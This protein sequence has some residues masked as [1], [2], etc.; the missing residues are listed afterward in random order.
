MSSN[1]IQKY[2]DGL[3]TE[4]EEM[5]LFNELSNNDEM[6]L[7]LRASLKLRETIQSNS[8]N[9]VPQKLLLNHFF[10]H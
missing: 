4:P 5:A 10:L 7:E 6:R 3:L 9:R 2:I 1:L 8:I